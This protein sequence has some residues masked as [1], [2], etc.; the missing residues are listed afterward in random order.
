MSWR[1]FFLGGKRTLARSPLLGLCPL[2]PKVANS[3]QLSKFSQEE[4]TPASHVGRTVAYENAQ[5]LRARLR[6]CSRG[7]AS[8]GHRS[9]IGVSASYDSQRLLE[10][11]GLN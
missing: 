6:R 8:L 7:L 4:R 1:P 3:L 2:Q 11:G 9:T 10:A 5:K